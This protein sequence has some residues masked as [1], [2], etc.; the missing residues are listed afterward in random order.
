MNRSKIEVLTSI[1]RSELIPALG[2]TEPIAVALASAKAKEVLG[3]DV[4]HINVRCSTNII[5]NAR[6]VFV[7]RTN[8]LKGIEAAALIG[9]FGGDASLGLEVLNNV[10]DED[11]TEVN[12]LVDSGICD[13]YQLDTPHKLDIVVELDGINDHTATVRVTDDHTNL[14][15]ILKD[16]EVLLSK[17]ITSLDEA[18]STQT[19]NDISFFDIYEYAMQVDLNAVADVIGRQIE[20][21]TKISNEGLENNYGINVGSSVLEF[22]GNSVETRAIA[23]AAAG[24]DARM[25]GCE[26]P[27]IINSGSGNQGLTVSLPI[28]EFA[29]FMETSQETLYRALILSNLIAI[30]QRTKIGRLS[31]LCGVVNAAA[32]VSAGLTL[33]YG[34]SEEQI[35]HAIEY[36]LGTMSGL[37]CDGA[38]A[39]CASKIAA[40]VQCALLGSKLSLNNHHFMPGDGIIKNSI[41]D[42]IDGVTKIGKEGMRGTDE[43]IVKLMLDDQLG[44]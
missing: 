25:G 24:S 32:G 13:V 31:A 22:S 1:L 16:N 27:V 36:V 7:P 20:F 12:R 3:E 28:V 4:R 14:T 6:S 37:I 44:C 5:K 43:I 42:T 38:K 17:E 26:L 29:R 39:S 30:Y 41:A 11:I 35:Y 9:I 23:K 8:G 40:C 33:L 15:Q 18:D 2:C 34:G 19:M 21:N 10:T